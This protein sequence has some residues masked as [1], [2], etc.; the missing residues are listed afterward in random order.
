MS[1]TEK[2]ARRLGAA[3]GI[4]FRRYEHWGLWPIKTYGNVPGGIPADFKNWGDALE[5]VRGLHGGETHN[6]RD[7]N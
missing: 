1:K 4:R 7:T 2:E 5:W 6:R 3:L